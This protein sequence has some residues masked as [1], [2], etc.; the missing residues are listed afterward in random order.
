ML[1]LPFRVAG[2]AAITIPIS[3]LMTLSSLYLFGVELHTVSLAALIVTLGMIVD[4]AIVIIDNH[5][6]KLDEG[7]TPWDA[8]WKSVS[9]LFVPV[10]IATLAIFSAFFPISMYLKGIGG[11]FTAS[12]PM[13]IGMALFASLLVAGFLVPFLSYLFIKKGL[14]TDKKRKSKFN[15]LDILQNVFN[16]S[17]DVAF[18]KPFIT[19]SI[20]VLS[21]ILGV[22]IFGN[23]KQQFFPKV[24]R[25]QFAVE[26]YLPEGEVLDNTA[27]VIDSLETALLS[28]KRVENV[29]SFVGT[30]SPRFHA[31]YA[32][33]IPSVNYGQ[34]IVNTISDE[35]TIEILDEYNKRFKNTFSNAHIKWKQLDMQATAPIEVRI[36]GNNIEELKKVSKT[37]TDILS[38]QNGVEWV[39]NDWKEK[40]QAISVKLDKD[41]ANRLGYNKG[42]IAT[43]LAVY[44][45][46]LPLTTIWEEDYPVDVVLTRETVLMI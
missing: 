9:E 35:A 46:G 21:I 2:V 12:F 33:N 20:G 10:F 40:R 17:L 16:K 6:E 37:V 45:K 11:D 38:R 29:T 24:E 34:L 5:V 31:V 32:P 15:L 22:I 14:H 28:D 3:I 39:R 7:E 4:N 1:L 18:K 25:N 41:K 27:K 23:V 36:S 44:L 19:I 42:L 13:A 43:N 26:V 30:S 8:A